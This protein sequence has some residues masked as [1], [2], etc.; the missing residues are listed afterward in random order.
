MWIQ[1]L[2]GAACDIEKADMLTIRQAASP[3]LATTDDEGKLCFG[4][5]AWNVVATFPDEAEGTKQLILT[6]HETKGDA[7]DQITKFVN[8]LNELSS[9]VEG[10]MESLVEDVMPDPEAEPTITIEE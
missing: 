8:A 9:E 3:P 7:K 6:Q 2:Y 10:Y 1:N 4:P 5:I